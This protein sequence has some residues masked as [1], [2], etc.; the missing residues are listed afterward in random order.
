MTKKAEAAAAG[1][2][3][4]VAAGPE[5]PTNIQTEFDTETLK[6]ILTDAELQNYGLLAARHDQEADPAELELTAV[7][8]QFKNRIDAATSKRKELASKIN[9]GYE[10]RTV[11]VQIVKD[12]TNNT[13][14]TIRQDTGETVKQ[15]TM[16]RQECQR[17]LEFPGEDRPQAA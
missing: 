15:C 13:V 1:T 8:S 2:L 7:K 16:T 3:A 11:D 6:C 9:Q 5:N 4:G 17:P 14:T 12:Y 10:F